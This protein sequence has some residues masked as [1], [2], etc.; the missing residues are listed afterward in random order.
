M[1]TDPA[2][3][4]IAPLPAQVDACELCTVNPE[5]L[6][7]AVVVRHPRGGVVQLAACDRCAAA[8]RR[9]IAVAGG[10]TSVGPAHVVSGAG[11]RSEAVAV[12]PATGR[13]L[14]VDAVG[15]DTIG[16]PVMIHEFLEAFE[17]EYGR[18]Y[19][20]RAYGQERTDGTWIGWLSFISSDAQL[21]RRT[22]RETT[23]SSR[24][25]LEYW[26]TG[27]QPSYL[28]GAFRRAS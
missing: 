8:V 11:N 19:A 14:A 2:S 22:G 12:E 15:S 4:S 21:T 28:E 26:A 27:I 6:R 13:P 23:Q 24:E 7:A 3:I 5:M 20:V 10:A 18:L 9:L 25:H 17:D 16:D 1:L